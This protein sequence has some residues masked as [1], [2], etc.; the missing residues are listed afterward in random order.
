MKEAVIVS[1]ART[2]IGSFQGQFGGVGAVNLG[3]AVIGTVCRKADLSP[4]RVDQ[5]WMGHVLQ[6]GLGM[7]PAR[8]A[9]IAAGLPYTVPAA[10]VGLV[11][12][13]GLLAVMEAARAVRSGDANWVIAGGMENMTQAPH[14]LPSLRGGV[15]YGKSELLDTIAHDGLTCSISRQA[16]GVTAE[17]LAERF[18]I[19]REA[20]DAY[21]ALSQQRAETAVRSGRFNDEIVPIEVR[22]RTGVR[23]AELD[24]HPRFGTTPEGLARLKLVFESGGTVTAGNASGMNDGAAAVLIAS[25]EE[26]RKHGLEFMGIIRAYATVGVE[27][28]WMGLGPVPALRKALGLAGLTLEQMDLIELNEAFASQTIACLQELG[29]GPERVNVN[30]GAIALGHPIGASGARILVTLLHE[31]KRRQGRFGAATLCVGG[32]HGVALIVE[33]M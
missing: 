10:S 20:Q 21:A 6:A 31:L 5:V 12:G 32:G 24:E 4:D 17:R 30:G 22:E 9:S 28:E 14:L 18:G 15:K 3:A 25:A 11:C 23:M 29:I 1:A 2:P 33:R 26:A 27:P 7:N 19:S 8:Q 13:S 16:M